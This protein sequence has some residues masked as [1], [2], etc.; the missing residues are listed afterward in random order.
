MEASLDEVRA[1]DALKRGRLQ[2]DAHRQ[3]G[4]GSDVRRPADSVDAESV[5]CVA[6]E[7]DVELGITAG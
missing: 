4:R 5:A 3:A 6:L 2:R 1:I 7:E